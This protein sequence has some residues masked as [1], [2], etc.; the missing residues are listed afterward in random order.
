MTRLLLGAL[1]AAL[2]TL[3]GL[4]GYHTVCTDGGPVGPSSGL[5]CTDDSSACCEEPTKAACCE[6]HS[7][8]A[9]ATPDCC[10]E[11]AAAAND[12]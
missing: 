3:T 11:K 8:S 7:A 1:V 12:K 6:Q 2:L 9:G 5:S 10:Q 4:V